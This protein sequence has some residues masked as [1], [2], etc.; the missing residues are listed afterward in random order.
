ME[1]IPYKIGKA[2]ED[3]NFQNIRGQFGGIQK[4]ILGLMQ[5][6]EDLDKR[7]EEMSIGAMPFEIDSQGNLMP[8]ITVFLLSETAFILDSRNCLAPTMAAGFL[9]ENFELDINENLIP[10]SV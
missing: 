6:L 2:R 9:D 1:K 10:R 5:Q 8:R 3:K 7:I 4:Q